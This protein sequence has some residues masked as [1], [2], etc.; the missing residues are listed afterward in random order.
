MRHGTI[1]GCG[2]VKR[3]LPLFLV[4][5]LMLTGC[6]STDTNGQNDTYEQISMSDGIERMESDKGYIL[7]D[8]RR[9]DEFAAGHIPGAVN[10]PNKRRRQLLKS[11]P[12]RPCR[13]P[14]TACFPPIGRQPFFILIYRKISLYA[15]CLTSR[16]RCLGSFKIPSPHKQDPLS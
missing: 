13:Y 6:G 4:S 7:L 12:N 5:L 15:L 16:H 1:R 14:R 3:I 2:M 9:A 11:T 10:L 8:V